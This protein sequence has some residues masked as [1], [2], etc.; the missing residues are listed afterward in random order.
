[1]KASLID[2]EGDWLS[3][4]NI[5][6]GKCMCPARSS[7]RPA[8]PS[9]RFRNRVSSADMPDLIVLPGLDG[10]TTLLGRVCAQLGALG[11][12]VGTL[13]YP[14]DKTLDYSE[15]ESLVRSQLPD[16]P[17]VLLGESFS[18]P[19]AIRIAS[20][21][22]RHLVG[23]ILST[24]FVR[25]PFPCLKP[26]AGLTRFA[27]TQLPATLLAWWLLG[28]WA[29]PSLKASLNL[30]VKSVRPSVLR[31]RVAAALR[32][33]ESRLLPRIRLP[34]LILVAS[35][36]RLLPVACSRELAVGLSRNRVVSIEGPH[37]LLQANVPACS[38]EIAAFVL[39]LDS[40]NPWKDPSSIE[41]E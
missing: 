39:G 5:V 32:V 29:T 18:G 21:P 14:P 10:T 6:L 28:R 22:P 27:P 8:S 4:D 2:S 37:F 1:L 36:D 26:I 12:G 11:I 31:V 3:L 13:A 30:A 23:L 38:K 41:S 25:S 9:I 19:L 17:F 40:A 20:D 34:A 24:T 35:Q 15:L 7:T 33:D 16:H